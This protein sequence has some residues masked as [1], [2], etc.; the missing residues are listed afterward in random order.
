MSVARNNV[1]RLI[2]C[3]QTFFLARCCAIASLRVAAMLSHNF[4]PPFLGGL[5]CLLRFG[6]PAPADEDGHRNAP[7]PRLNSPG[8]DTHLF[9]HGL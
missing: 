7:A 2:E 3:L 6:V 5:A 9:L 1:A 4:S 8:R